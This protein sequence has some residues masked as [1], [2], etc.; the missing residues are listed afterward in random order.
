MPIAKPSDVFLMQVISI[1]I[2]FETSK[3]RKSLY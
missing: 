2:I 1:S 3:I